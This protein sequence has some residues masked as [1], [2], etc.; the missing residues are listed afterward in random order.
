MK[1]LT[2]TDCLAR[3]AAAEEAAG[4]LQLAW[5]DLPEEQAAGAALAARLQREADGWYERARRLQ[6]G[7]PVASTS[8]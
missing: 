1:A 5:T 6:A 3:A 7:R 8:T 4:H 2:E